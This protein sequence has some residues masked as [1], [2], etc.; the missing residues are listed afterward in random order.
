MHLRHKAC[1]GTTAFSKYIQKYSTLLYIYIVCVYLCSITTKL[2]K[3]S[4]RKKNR[5]KNNP[6]FHILILNYFKIKIHEPDAIKPIK[7]PGV[8]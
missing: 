7:L 5:L 4:D 2:Y 3:D 1:Q 8:L 6:F